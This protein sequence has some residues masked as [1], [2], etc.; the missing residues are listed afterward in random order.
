[1]KRRSRE[2][3]A[4]MQ[5]IQEQHLDKDA[6]R[7]LD[8]T[9]RLTGTS[10]VKLLKMFRSVDRVKAAILSISRQLASALI[11]A[12]RNLTAEARRCMEEP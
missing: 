11:P 3:R 5:I 10:Y 4:R 2:S 9:V 12:F 1:M 8:Q 6:Q 7:R